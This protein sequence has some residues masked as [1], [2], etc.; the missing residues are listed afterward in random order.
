MNRGPSV[1]YLVVIT[2]CWGCGPPPA[3]DVVSV[4]GPAIHRVSRPLLLSEVEVAATPADLLERNFILQNNTGAPQ[5]VSLAGTSCSCYGVMLD[6]EPWQ[7]GASVTLPPGTVRSL[8]FDVAPPTEV[9]EKTW[10]IRLASGD[11]P[12]REQ[13]LTLEVHVYDDITLQPAVFFVRQPPSSAGARQMSGPRRMTITRTWRRSEQPAAAPE[14]HGLPQW[15]SF[16]T[17]IPVDE[18]QEIGEGL[19]RQSWETE[20]QFAANDA[21][22]P[23]M[24][25]EMQARVRE[26]SVEFGGPN[27][28]TVRHSARLVVEE[29]AGVTAPSVVHWGRL[30]QSSSRMRRLVLASADRSPFRIEGA[31]LVVDRQTAVMHEREPPASDQSDPEELR[32]GNHQTD[33][34]A[35]SPSQERRADVQAADARGFQYTSPHFNLDVSIEEATVDGRLRVLLGL[36]PSLAGP[37]EATLVFRT[38]HPLTPSLEIQLRALVL[39]DQDIAEEA[40]GG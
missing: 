4:G 2:S 6:G 15:A 32:N 24:P 3:A 35:P 11:D 26:F 39:R 37:L 18:P 30:S 14:I 16:S 21:A 7:K 28:R 19:W 34:S 12:P 13:M 17:P 23:L 40:A 22:S 1:L 25:Q 36:E 10:N 27:N 8:T 5:T 20:L 33:E 9:S 38:D 29:A 31:E